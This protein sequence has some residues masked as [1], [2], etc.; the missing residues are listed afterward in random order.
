MCANW[1]SW[2]GR[3]SGVAPMSSTT[4]G[5]FHDGSGWTIAGRSTPGTKQKNDIGVDFDRDV[6]GTN[7]MLMRNQFRAWAKFMAPSEKVVP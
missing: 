1:C 7:E 4:I 5:P 2:L 6:N 3:G